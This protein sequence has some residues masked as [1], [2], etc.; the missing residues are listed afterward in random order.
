MQGKAHVGGHVTLIFSVQDDSEHLLEQ[1]S[2]GAGISLDRG[3]IIEVQGQPGNGKITTIEGDA[4]GSE[5]HHLV[6]DELK[7][8]EPL[9]GE[10]DWTL[11]HEGELPASQ[12]FG[13]SAAGAI[14][15]ALA[16]Q[17]ALGV[18]EQ[19]ARSQAIHVAHRV[20]RRL[21]G[22]LG[23][24]AALHAGGI[25]L[26][27]NQGVHNYQT[28][29]ADQGPSS[30]GTKTSP[31]SLFGGPLQ[32][33]T[34]QTILTMENGSSP[35]VLRE[36]IACLDFVKVCGMQNVGLNCCRRVQNLLNV[37]ACW[38]IPTASVFSI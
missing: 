16:L 8:L 33:N 13:L 6:L 22:G 4:P 27:L 11:R 38:E 2:R 30:H 10:N 20:E 26:R 17:R 34:L 24:V 37:Q 32:V 7:H 1:G 36:N 25:E 18:D 23:D 28:T 3:V 14:A 15:C 12:G 9:F 5:L 21:S 29:S 19:L 31:S 35:F